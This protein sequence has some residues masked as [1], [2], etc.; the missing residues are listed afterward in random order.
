MN[1]HDK[2]TEHLN[3]LGGGE[4]IVFGEDIGKSDLMPCVGLKIKL[5]HPAAMVPQQGS[6]DSAGYDLYCIEDFSIPAQE[7]K[8]VPLG[9]ATEIPKE[10]HVRIESRSGL[11]TKGLVVL[12]GVIDSDY[13]GQWH[14]ILRNVT[15]SPVHFEKGA[16]VAQMVIR[17]TYRANFTEVAELEESQRGTGGFGSTGR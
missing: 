2:T 9:F 13:R 17:P 16:K 15:L 8:M 7:T 4:T 5:L 10:F 12:T 14:V 11:A 3:D 1:E 6:P